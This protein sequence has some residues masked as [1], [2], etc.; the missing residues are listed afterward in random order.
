MSIKT[1]KAQVV[2]AAPDTEHQH[3]LFLLLQT[4]EKRGGFW[5]NATGKIEEGESF[6]EGAIREVL[7]ETQLPQDLIMDLV[8]LEMRHDFLDR[9]DR[10]VHEQSFLLVTQ[11]KW[12]VKI[13]P[14]E[15]QNFRW[16]PLNEIQRDSVKFEGNYDALKKSCDILR[17][18][19]AS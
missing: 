10:Q 2:I 5:Q 15:H 17:R 18:W 6:E 4:N 3:F 13:D 14:E 1:K 19:R 8:D 16:V 11:E 12:D 9:W 7:E